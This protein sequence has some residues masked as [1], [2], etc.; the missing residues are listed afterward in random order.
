MITSAYIDPSYRAK[1]PTLSYLD[2]H[3]INAVVV[4]TAWRLSDSDIYTSIRIGYGSAP[5]ERP[6]PA[7]HAMVNTVVR[8][9]IWKLSCSGIHTGVEAVVGSATRRP[10]HLWHSYSDHWTSKAIINREHQPHPGI[11][12]RVNGPDTHQGFGP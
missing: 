11:H 4:P 10:T 7:I 8:S 2:N 5:W 3:G 6:T 12:A 1:A 9:I